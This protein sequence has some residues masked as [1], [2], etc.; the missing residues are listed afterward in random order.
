[1]NDT[2]WSLPIRRGS[3]LIGVNRVVRKEVPPLSDVFVSLLSPDL[4][5]LLF[6]TTS[7]IILLKS[8][9]LEFYTGTR[10]D[11]GDLSIRKQTYDPGGYW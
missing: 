2:C 4:D 10:L 11:K 9:V 6:S 7:E 5:L 3:F 1:M 8:L